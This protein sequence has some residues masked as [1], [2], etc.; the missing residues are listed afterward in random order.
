MRIS[1]AASSGVATA[2]TCTTSPTCAL[3]KAGPEYRVAVLHPVDRFNQSPGPPFDGDHAVDTDPLTARQQL[4]RPD[5]PSVILRQERS[6]GVG[7]SARRPTPLDQ[8]Q[9]VTNEVFNGIAHHADPQLRR[10]LRHVAGEAA[11]VGGA[12]ARL[13]HAGV[14]ALAQVLEEGTGGPA[15]HASRHEDRIKT[16]PSRRNHAAPL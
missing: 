9:L 11:L 4:A 13:V 3:L 7:G 8:T 5:S 16:K 12:M 6:R 15:P 14:D 10:Q 1:P 2:S